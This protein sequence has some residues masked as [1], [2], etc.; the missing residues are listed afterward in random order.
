MAS[1]SSYYPQPV[2]AGTTA[3][4][5]AEGNDSRIEGS[6]PA[7]TAGTG[8]VLA[9]SSSVPRALSDRFSDSEISV[10]DYGAIPNKCT[11]TGSISGTTL[12]VTAI[13]GSTYDS[14]GFPLLK[15]LEVGMIIDTSPVTPLT[16]I[17]QVLTGA[18]GVG[19][20]QVNFSQ[21]VTSTTLDAWYDNRLPIQRAI[22][23]SKFPDSAEVV[24]NWTFDTMTTASN[25]LGTDIRKFPSLIY[26][27][28][29]CG[30]PIHFPFGRYKISGPIYVAP[31]AHLRGDTEKNCQIIPFRLQQHNIIED[32]NVWI[33]RQE[34]G[35]DGSGN[36]VSW[37]SPWWVVSRLAF[38]E[39][40]K[41]EGL[42]FSTVLTNND[43]L[44][45]SW[46]QWPM[47]DETA[48][49]LC[50]G[51]AGATSF[52]VTYN[53]GSGATS[54]SHL[55]VGDKVRFKGFNT[56]YTIGS[57]S[58]S[59][60]N[61]ASGETL[62]DNIT[63]KILML[64]VLASNGIM[65]SG[66]ENAIVDRCI[67]NN[68]AGVGVWCTS[69]SPG[70]TVKDTMVNASNVA[71]QMDTG[72]CT[73]FKPSG[74]NNNTLIS[75]GMRGYAL[76]T[77]INHKSEET[78]D[79]SGVVAE[80]RSPDI[81]NSLT[82]TNA[83]F[84]VGAGGIT[85]VGGSTNAG[86][87]ALSY[88]NDGATLDRAFINAWSNLTFELFP[89][90]NIVNSYNGQYGTKIISG[91]NSKTGAYYRST[92][93]LDT[94]DGTNFT[95]QSVPDFEG[96]FLGPWQE[97]ITSIRFRGTR[98]SQNDTTWCGITVDQGSTNNN[99]EN[100]SSGA[101][102]GFATFTRSGT[103]VTMS[104]NNHGF[105]V[106]DYVEITLSSNIVPLDVV[107]NFI[108]LDNDGTTHFP[109][110]VYRVM[111]APN[112]NSFTISVS[113]NAATPTTG[114]AKLVALQYIVL[115]DIKDGVHR[116]QMPS[117]LGSTASN[118]NALVV[119][120]KFRR[121]IAGLRVASSQQGDWWSSNS[122]NIGGTIDSPASR[123]LTGTG[124]QL[125]ANPTAPNGSLFLRTD[126]DASTTLY[127]RASGVWEPLVSY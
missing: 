49:S 127:V 7:A 79:V 92:G 42:G 94:E 51:T 123:I 63:N 41:I 104:Y 64:G 121:N 35:L 115:H 37:D 91:R 21:N 112:N 78:R 72:P 118:R 55:K 98:N 40:L 67:L 105:V 19:T 86:P 116:I 18:G 43:T 76:T 100:I 93:R 101:R 83:H 46:Y 22:A 119:M 12:T 62:A 5:Y 110:R 3:G 44:E 74:D 87:N 85:I 57:I 68:F 54:L 50:T 20:Y 16:K 97:N 9:K 56:A 124:A 125:S 96:N 32:F 90:I 15:K 102:S 14:S 47:Y 45:Y 80:G 113:D 6:L 111:S 13:S 88:T 28:G 24:K 48:Y 114:T 120:D 95:V 108:P 39:N 81:Y 106:G 82:S 103:A 36:T 33:Q 29:P 59:T 117:E 26:L 126:G 52:T 89:R 2:I 122:L 77:S 23:G 75:S 58:G 1:L 30:R 53:G 84:E 38:N 8:S 61:L 10:L 27:A 66:G 109:T 99:P 73:L 31:S 34:S 70:F 69:G 107:A 60:V 65:C 4:T 71:F 17:T 25:D 11:F